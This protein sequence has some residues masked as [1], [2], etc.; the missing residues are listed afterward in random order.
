M[1][2][3]ASLPFK[4]NPEM[5]QG[6]GARPTVYAKYGLNGH[7]GNDW[8]LPEGTLLYA[9]VTGKVLKTGNDADGWGI[10][11]QIF[12]PTQNLLINVTHLQYTTTWA[13]KAVKAGDKI[14]GSGNTGFSSAPHVHV[15]AA[16]TD[17]SG[18]IQNTGNGYHGWYSVMDGGRIILMP[19]PTTTTGDASE[20][21]PV[22]VTFDE[23]YNKYYAGWGRV[24]AEADFNNTYKGDLNLLKVARGE[25]PAGS[26]EIRPAELEKTYYLIPAFNGLSLNEI[27]SGIPLGRVDI[28]AEMLGLD[29][30]TKLINGQALNV[31]K[32]PTDYFPSSS[33]WLGFKKLVG[34]TPVGT[35]GGYYIKPEWA[36]K[37]LSDIN[38][39][40]GNTGR[41]DILAGFLGISEY[42]KIPAYQ[43]FGIQGFPSSY[44]P[45]SSEW[46]GFS[47]LFTQTV[48]SQPK[49]PTDNPPVPGPEV[50]N[51][52]P[53]DV[54]EGLTPADTISTN[55]ALLTEQL[56]LILTKLNTILTK[57]GSSTASTPSS[58]PDAEEAT[59][60]LF[61]NSTPNRAAIYLDDSFQYDYTPSN[62]TYQIAPG[63]HTL[64]LKKSG[65][66]IYEE[67]IMIEAELT[68]SVNIQ[69][70]PLAS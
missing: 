2:K 31:S 67:E 38:Q 36:N 21:S 37:S 70:V 30:N 14:G 18:N 28:L 12:D 55:N 16:D 54:G 50:I 8:V 25:S 40:G 33:E 19:L 7:D 65:F 46:V 17:S 68:K 66:Q 62:F 48:P 10:Y 32:F 5:T 4:G 29:P 9:P 53:P 58:P 15:A 22:V 35:P 24:E 39:Q 64:K 56:A 49:A 63:S 3:Q 57:L 20:T 45:T 27:S 43:G 52:N 1:A 6:F 41:P 61:V 11:T 34:L 44:I 69:L 23:I 60:G 51:T 13:G 59:G 42:Y 47:S 26:V